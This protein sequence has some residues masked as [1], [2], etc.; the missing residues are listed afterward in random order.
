MPGSLSIIVCCHNGASRLP[1]T[2]A[3]IRN[4]VTAPDI[5]W[6]VIVVDNA[7]TD[8]TAD[9]A[10]RNW[11]ID[12]PAPM[13]VITES[14]LGLA[15]ARYRGL[16]ESRGEWVSLVD[17][18]NWLGPDW[19]QR[20]SN[21]MSEHPEVAALGG[22]TEAVCE[23]PP[24]PWFPDYQKAYAVGRQADASGDV[25]WT[26]GH[27][28]GAG[29]TVRKSAWEKLLAEGF[30][31]QLRDRTGGTLSSGADYELC[32]ALRLAGW[33]IWYCDDLFL[34]HYIPAA[35]L[36][37]SYLIRLFRGFGAQRVGFD[38]YRIFIALETNSL[39][40]RM[41]KSWLLQTLREVVTGLI[42]DKYLWRVLIRNE[43]TVLQTR[44]AFSYR[45]GR[46][47]ALWAARRTYADSVDTVATAP[48]RHIDS[49]AA[50]FFHK[51]PGA[52]GSP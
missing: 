26:L 8:G 38:P 2:L 32:Y 25:T 15:H 43:M 49:A 40:M 22:R 27:L 45:K 29:L 35:R 20:V 52:T 44:V 17:D 47:G 1:E 36:T 11:G 33:R 3:H 46:I 50:R 19:V 31:H 7:S 10:R 5:Q 12:A 42:R 6:E 41:A 30:A 24:P 18:D 39:L 4:Q 21:I 48:W 23:M 14:R 16:L 28:W 51:H 9:V 34:R 13:R 37:E